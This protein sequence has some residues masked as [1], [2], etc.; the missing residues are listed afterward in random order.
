MRVSACEAIDAII[1]IPSC[2]GMTDKVDIA[3]IFLFMFTISIYN[4]KMFADLKL[5]P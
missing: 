3:L 1:Q 2:E 5:F 4:D